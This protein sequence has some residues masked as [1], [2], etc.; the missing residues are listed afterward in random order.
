MDYDNKLKT[1]GKTADNVEVHHGTEISFLQ[2]KI[3]NNICHR[4][5][6]S[7][8]V[9]SECLMGHIILPQEWHI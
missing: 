6:K 4:C 7:G 9:S 2:A 1:K 8:Q 3:V 5:V